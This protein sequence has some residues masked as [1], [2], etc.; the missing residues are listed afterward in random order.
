MNFIRSTR[1]QQHGGAFI[2]MLVIMILGI[3]TVLIGALSGVGQK[4][5]NNVKSGEVLLQ[6]RDALIAYA[7]SDDNRPGELICPDVN[8]DGVITASA[9]LS[10]SNC[11]SL[12]G[13]LPWKTLGIP[14]LR[15]A[16]GERLWYALSDPFHANGTTTLN[17]D[18]SGTITITGTATNVI[19]IVFAP[20][21]ALSTQSRGDVNTPCTLPYASDPKC[22]PT[23]YLE[24]GISSPFQQLTQ[25]DHE[26]GA[27]TYNDQLVYIS[28]DHLMPLIEKRIA[29]EVKA[30]LDDYASD[31]SNIAHKYPWAAPVSD[32]T[33]YPARNGTYDVRFGRMPELV[34]RNTSSGGPLTPDDAAMQAEILILQN[35]LNAYLGGTGTL[36]NLR[37]KG[38]NLKDLVRDP[39]YNQ[40]AGDPAYDA[41]RAAEICSGM[42]CTIS[43]AA[44]ITNALNSIPSGVTTDGTMPAS[45]T[46]SCNTLLLTSNYWPQWRDLVFYQVAS[47]YQPGGGG[48]CTAGITCLSINGNG[49][50]NTGN[51]TYHAAVV[52][53]GKL[54]TGQ[55]RPSTA[56]QPSNYL[57]AG[58][59]NSHQS[60]AGANPATTFTTYRISDT[61]YSSATNDLAQCVDGKD[62]CK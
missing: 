40:T 37:N 5:A 25:D 21:K 57:E 38:D 2:V 47:G 41:G 35:A 54:R 42:S 60:V 30:C 24:S 28:H 32:T 22:I 14:D 10:G 49:N 46:I 33:A 52:V 45:W 50:P 7:V 55:A 29:R 12:I 34:N 23:N 16:S 58:A 51:G 19:A 11:V 56:N 62:K 3:S 1:Q 6:A 59:G 9:D 31:G 48:S 26:G 4:A 20:N 39:P 15:D 43:L 13:R 17:S 36:T 27:Y 8:N 61:N 18:T 44:L 53:A